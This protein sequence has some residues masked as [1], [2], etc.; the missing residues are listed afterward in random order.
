MAIERDEIIK[1]GMDRRKLLKL[2]GAGTLGAVLV[3]CSPEATV[4]RATP[5]ATVGASEAATATPTSTATA[6]ATAEAAG[7]RQPTPTQNADTAGAGT[8]GVETR[9]SGALVPLE[10]T[11]PR[12][13][14]GQRMAAAELGVSGEPSANP[15][16]WRINEYGAPWI[17]AENLT[18]RGTRVRTVSGWILDGSIKMPGEVNDQMGVVVEGN[19]VP[20]GVMRLR[21]FTAWH[22]GVANEH[23]G[24][25]QVFNQQRAR[26][27]IEQP[28]V[29]TILV[30]PPGQVTPITPK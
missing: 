17:P 29:I 7:V 3:A 12:N 8:A 16:V 21:G 20:E 1:K 27:A 5:G 24:A 6:T 2:A 11:F 25:L 15:G 26:E 14:E 19:A 30:C 4:S 13:A 9:A 28:G 10:R 18:D 23:A 22:F